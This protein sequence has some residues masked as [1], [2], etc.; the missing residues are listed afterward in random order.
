MNQMSATVREVA[1]NVSTTSDAAGA[2]NSE[3]ETGRQ[4]V[5]T[6][7]DGIQRLA[8]QIEQTAL[9]IS[10]VEQNS[11]HINKVLE[12][13]RG[14]AE[15]TNLLALNAAIEAARA[16][17]Q[18]RGFA[19]VADEV[20][21][22]AGRTQTSTAEISEII[23]KLQSGSRNAVAVMNKSRAQAHTVVE[24]A[25]L[26]GTSLRTIAQAV[27]QIN[28]MSA[29]IATA[30]EEQ[31][32]VTD[33]MNQSIVRIN[34]MTMQNATGAEQTSTSGHELADMVTELQGLVGRFRVQ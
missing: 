8:E 27:S 20:R 17:E 26:A 22:L 30:T 12:V 25:V 19:V 9:V 11:E 33:G 21:T 24:Q 1:R 32:A 5:D 13:I 28:T 23:D 3:T 2:A 18:G 10:E 6:A 16:G 34:E 31:S 14:I 29:Q 7:V 4:V 15:Q